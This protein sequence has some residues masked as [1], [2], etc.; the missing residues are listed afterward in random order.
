MAYE[1]LFAVSSKMFLNMQLFY[2]Q[3]IVTKLI[4]K[5]INTWIKKLN[6]IIALVWKATLT[7]FYNLLIEDGLEMNCHLYPGKE[8]THKKKTQ[9]VFNKMMKKCIRV[10][11]WQ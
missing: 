10:K 11:E 4:L 9:L 5:E 1:L 6:K 8:I 2:K 3:K 7:W